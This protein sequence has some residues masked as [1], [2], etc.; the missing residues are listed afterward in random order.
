MRVSRSIGSR[1]T[2]GS[3]TSFRVWAPLLQRVDLKVVW[4]EE[5][6]I[7]MMP[8]PRGYFSAQVPTLGPGTR[9]FYLLNREQERP[10]PASRFQPEDV[11]GPSEVTDPRF[12]WHDQ[13]WPGVLLDD[14]ILYELHVGTFTPEGTFDAI[15]PHLDS[16]LD[17]G[18]TVLEIMPVAQFPGSRNWGYDGVY[19]FA[20]QSSYGGYQGLRRLVDA[21]H[22]KGLGIVLDVVY[23]HLGPEG[24]YHSEFGPY[25]T[26]KYETPWGRGVNFD[27]PLSDEVRTY[28]VENALQWISAFHFDGL[29][30]D[31]I[32]A[33]LDFSVEPFLVDLGSAVSECAQQLNRRVY[34]IA[35]SDRN[36]PGVV[37][38]IEQGGFGLDAVWNDGFHHALHTQLTGERQ[39]YYA[40]YQGLGDLV[41]AYREGFNYSG[42]F[43]PYRQR[44]HGASS[45]AIPARRF[46]VFTQNHDQVG[47]RA[48]GDRLCHQVTL[49]ARK[50]SAG[51]VL[52]SP[53][54]PLLFMGEEY[55][56][57]APFTFFV[58]H[59]DPDLCEAVR[60]G[61]RKE[62]AD[63]QWNLEIPDPVS[64]ETFMR[65][66]LD[67]S[68]KEGGEHKV[69][70]AFYRELIWLRKSLP[71][72]RHL[73]K[74]TQ[75]V[76]SY[77][78]K[79]SV[80]IKRWTGDSQV[81]VL[82]HFGQSPQTLSLPFPGGEWRKILDSTEER[83]LGPGSKIP[84]LVISYGEISLDLTPLSVFVL[85]RTLEES[86]PYKVLDF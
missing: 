34:L 24:A 4:P 60:Q 69:L 43:S 61:R 75:E 36:D 37:R 55:G 48:L 51:T 70:Y 32:H 76:F 77:P 6:V 71:A 17:L 31:A 74:K 57:K 83:W 64:E 58:S 85:A 81:L 84:E 5:K 22:Q 18:V 26:D 52:L 50:L 73:S 46:V 67:H 16:L 65:S 59:L 41:K 80:I 68:L 12:D 86:Y 82:L 39:G 25:F 19:P 9:Y 62:F 1:W 47:N 38:S 30:L 72:L 3:G 14:Y 40:D 15:I 53:F 54:I 56:E 33:I 45:V 79:S 44:R 7:E 35:E 11:H 28:W 66:K 49:E 23:N 42:Q 27:G 2:E 10:D 20:P 8:E 29:R 78:N 21:C 63:F 13:S